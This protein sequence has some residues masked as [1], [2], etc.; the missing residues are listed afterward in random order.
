MKTTTFTKGGYEYTL[1]ADN[2]EGDNLQ[3]FLYVK[4]AGLR[5]D[6]LFIPE[7]QILPS[8]WLAMVDHFHQVFSLPKYD[9]PKDVA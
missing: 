3:A 4:T 1:I 5:C 6:E 7:D 2:I 8:T 9:H